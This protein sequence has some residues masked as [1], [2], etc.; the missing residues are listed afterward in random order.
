MDALIRDVDYALRTLWKSR[1]FTAVAVATLALGIGANVAV[2]SVIDAVVLRPLPYPD[3]TRLLLVLEANEREGWSEFPAAWANVQ[4]WQRGSRSLDT[5]AGF[6]ERNFTVTG[7]QQPEQLYGYGIT[8]GFMEMLG[9]Q[10][11]SGRLFRPEE[12]GPEG[13]AV[14]LISDTFWDRQFGRDPDAVGHTLILD[15]V[16]VSVVG[17]LPPEAVDPVGQEFHLTVPLSFAARDLTSR[18]A[19][20]L[21]VYGRLAPEASLDRARAELT[22]IA[23]GLALE[24]PETNRDWTVTVQSLTEQVVGPV[25]PRLLAVQGVVLLVL[26]I[27]L[28]NVANLLLVRATQ[29]EREISIRAAVGGSRGRIV[30]QLCTESVLLV[31][32]GGAIGLLLAWVCKQWLLWALLAEAPTL[33]RVAETT[34]N[35]RVFGFAI[36][37]SGLSTVLFGLLPAWYSAA[38]DLSGTLRSCGSH[39]SDRPGRSILRDIFTV[40]EIAV[41]LVLLS[42]AGLLIKDL[43]TSLPSSPGFDMRDKLTVRVRLQPLTYGGPEQRL[44]FVDAVVQE[45]DTLPGV[46]SV[47]A[48]NFLPFDNYS[49]RT[50][51]EVAGRPDRPLNERPVEYRAI[52]ANYFQTLGLPVRQGRPFRDSDDATGPGVMIL[53]T[54]LA[55]DLFGDSLA[56]GQQLELRPW[57]VTVTRTGETD[58][59][60]GT[61]VGV[62]SDVIEDEDDVAGPKRVVYVPYRQHPDETVSLVVSAAGDAGALAPPVRAR[63]WSIDPDQ[64]LA[65][66]ATFDDLLDRRFASARLFRDLM[67]AFALI[68]LALAAI[69]VYGVLA[70]AFARRRQEMGSRLALG[71]APGDLFRLVMW[72][73]ARLT[74]AGLALGLAGSWLLVRVFSSFLPAVEA[75]GPVTLGQAALVLVAVTLLAAYLPARRAARADPL[76]ALRQE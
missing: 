49:V 59:R 42:G 13:N 19:R 2:F 25:R 31:A 8:R 17:I 36:L 62:V 4:D 75:W 76:S 3:P 11:A 6:S 39:G 61:V 5:L 45:L 60:T 18:A 7:A 64:P 70:Y 30:R 63:I 74:A 51:V 48:A 50:Y 54:R 38:P 35:V 34:L 12:Y 40:A 1:V 32:A 26:L 55:R 71:A 9:V 15:G 23:S 22:A 56:I 47:A 44:A 57:S 58:P 24:F 67:V 14:A 27:A 73:A 46:Q 29:R 21:V 16:G 43:M 66:V 41:S 10:P 20:Q 69:G 72:R 68:G 33:P 28:A 65:N 53:N 37:I 52:S